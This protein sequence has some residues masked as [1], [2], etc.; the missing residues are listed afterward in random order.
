M[1]Q[2]TYTVDFDMYRFAENRDYIRDG[3][4]TIEIKLLLILIYIWT[5][6]IIETKK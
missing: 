3:R 6:R 4:F 1:P 5:N 2:L